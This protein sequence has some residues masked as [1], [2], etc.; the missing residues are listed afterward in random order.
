MTHASHL[1]PP[2][3][4][5]VDDANLSSTHIQVRSALEP[6]RTPSELEAA[7]EAW[8]QTGIPSPE[9]G[10]WERAGWQPEETTLWWLMGFN[11][12]QATF[13]LDRLR[14]S[15]ASAHSRQVQGARMLE[16]FTFGLSSDD[17]VLLV[18]AGLHGDEEAAQMGKALAR[19][20]GA[21]GSLVTRACLADA[22]VQ[23]LLCRP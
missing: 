9:I 21:R 14:P 17:I 3:A 19:D 11:P 13:V 23:R 2:H 22:D 20:V 16:W 7:A 18:A 8:E 12:E 10:P 4:Q 1:F 6:V 15:T 5:V